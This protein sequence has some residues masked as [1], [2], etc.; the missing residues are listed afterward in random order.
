[1]NADNFAEWKRRQGFKVVRSESSYWYEASPH[2]FQ[3]F[4]YHWLITPSEQEL[5]DLL[6]HN[7]IYALRYS[8]PVEAPVGKISYHIIKNNPY[9][10][11]T[12]KHKSHKHILQGMSLCTVEEISMTRLAEEGWNLQLDSLLRQHRKD[13]MRREEWNE[14]CL[15][16]EG[17]PGFEAWGALVN[18]DL[19]ASLLITRIDNTCVFLYFNSHQKYFDAY[20][21]QVLFFSVAR[22][23]LQREGIHSV[24]LTLQSLDAPK[25]VD[26]FKFRL[27]FDPKPVCQRVIFHPSIRPFANQFT[28]RLT[29]FLRNVWRNSSLSKAEGMLNFYLQGKLP[30]DRQ[31]WPECLQP[32]KEEMLKK[33]LQPAI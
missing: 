2:V 9:S 27:G 8:T 16:A 7:R 32:F 29:H 26:E 23:M 22:G 20:A 18:G 19:A 33:D 13:S 28:Y 1:M 30:L 10:L 15:T 25:S 31:C 21:G 6:V 4:P 24:F 3:A 5:H 12:I 14:L 11:D 17:I